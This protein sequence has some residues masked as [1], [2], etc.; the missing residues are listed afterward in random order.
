[1]ARMHCHCS[2]YL[3]AY[4]RWHGVF[5]CC[6]DTH[7]YELCL[8]DSV[9][10]INKV[11][12]RDQE[13]VAGI[14]PQEAPGTK[15]QAAFRLGESVPSYLQLCCNSEIK[16]TSES[17]SVPVRLHGGVGRQQPVSSPFSTLLCVVEVWSIHSTETQ[18]GTAPAAR[19]LF[20]LA[21]VLS[22]HG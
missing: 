16:C 9:Q 1:M 8:W 12:E 22:R 17:L 5:R 14:K 19:S 11:T 6:L 20:V 3:L 4:E 21:A 2:G 15:P 10:L 7:I 18:N 13:A